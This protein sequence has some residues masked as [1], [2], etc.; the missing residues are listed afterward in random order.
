MFCNCVF[1]VFFLAKWHRVLGNRQSDVRDINIGSLPFSSWPFNLSFRRSLLA[2]HIQLK[3][4]RT[5]SGSTDVF[6][7]CQYAFI[8]YIKLCVDISWPFH[9]QD[10]H[11]NSSVCHTF[12]I[13]LLLITWCLKNQSPLHVV[14][15]CPC[16]HLIPV[17]LTI[18]YWY[19]EQ[20]ILVLI[21]HTW[22]AQDSG[23]SRWG[24]EIL[25]PTYFGWKKKKE[26]KPAGQLK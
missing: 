24:G 16:S 22:V 11:M 9:S 5:A 15:I 19:C 10:F 14:D 8:I 23:G 21:G 1:L 13:L 20:K 2:Q 3:F 17:R 12:L 6:K 4:T 18:I 7:F 25:P 26:K